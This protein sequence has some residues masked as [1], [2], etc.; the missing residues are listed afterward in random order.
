MNDIESRRPVLSI[1]LTGS[2]FLRWYWLKDELADFA[3]GL[4]L[5]A[6]GSKELLTQRIAATLDV[7]EF[8]EP[9]PAK[10]RSSAQLFGVLTAQTVI[11]RGQR[12]SQVLR[13]WFT[14]ELGPGFHF[15]APMREFI[16]AA[17]GNRNLGQALEHWRGTRAPEER[18]E[19]DRQFEYNR[20]TR[21]WHGENPHGTK[22]ELLAAWVRYRGLPIDERAR[23]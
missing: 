13:A 21:A 7:R 22:T 14:Q 11:P 4:G 9:T 15:D 3:R 2:E 5:R 12:C 20:F 1:E 18:R 23:I 16:A 6:T 8:N 17:D 19:I 10:G